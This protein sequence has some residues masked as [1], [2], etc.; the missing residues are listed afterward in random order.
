MAL[1]GKLINLIKALMIYMI[2]LSTILE[3][4]KEIRD[5]GYIDI[6]AKDYYFDV[7][8][9]DNNI[10]IKLIHIYQYTD[11]NN[12]IKHNK[13]SKK[14]TAINAS[15][16][17]FCN[18]LIEIYETKL[19]VGYTGNIQLENLIKRINVNKIKL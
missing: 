3:P 7:E 6:D 11:D 18:V 16:E 15:I 13:V 19:Q 12:R 14:I 4:C 10:I 9:I 17:E 1:D 2:K 8:Y 5:N